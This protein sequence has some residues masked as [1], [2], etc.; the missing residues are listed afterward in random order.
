MNENVWGF[1]IIFLILLRNVLCKLK[2][3]LMVKL[4]VRKCVCICILICVCMYIINN[5]NYWD[6]CFIWILKIV[7]IDNILFYFVDLMYKMIIN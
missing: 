5:I 7:K 4:I 6:C 2:K 3:F 1:D